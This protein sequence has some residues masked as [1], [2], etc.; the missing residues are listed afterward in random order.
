MVVTALAL[1]PACLFLS[2]FIAH[3]VYEMPIKRVAIHLH[4]GPAALVHTQ[5]ILLEIEQIQN[6]SIDHHV[7]LPACHLVSHTF[8][9]FSFFL[10]WALMNFN[11]LAGHPRLGLD[12]KATGLF[13]L[14]PRCGCE[15]LANC[16]AP[17][18]IT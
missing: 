6:E 11:L 12:A 16:S 14:N 18:N 17:G 8:F 15:D 5:E 2:F 13:L 4:E 10:I 3:L 7:N 9:F 1:S